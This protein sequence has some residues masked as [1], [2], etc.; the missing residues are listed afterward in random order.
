MTIACYQQT[1]LS[2]RLTERNIM[3]RQN[4]NKYTYKKKLVS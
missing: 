4:N 1:T 3:W 2:H